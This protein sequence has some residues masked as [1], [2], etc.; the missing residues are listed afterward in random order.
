[1]NK[2]FKWILANAFSA[3]WIAATVVP[4][5]GSEISVKVV[6]CTEGALGK[7]DFDSYLKEHPDDGRYISIY[8]STS[9]AK[10]NNSGHVVYFYSGIGRESSSGLGKC[11]G[12][13]RNKSKVKEFLEKTKQELGTKPD[14]HKTVPYGK[15]L[16]PAGMQISTLNT[17]GGLVIALFAT[18]KGIDRGVRNRVE[19]VVDLIKNRYLENYRGRKGKVIPI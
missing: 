8:N 18:N 9:N 1:M 10:M 6:V 12:E 7:S 5:L 2:K 16:G 17:E 14:W 4:S 15:I 13:F 11:R 19:M 3:I